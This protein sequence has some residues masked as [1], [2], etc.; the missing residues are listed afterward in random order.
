MATVNG[1]RHSAATS[2]GTN[3]TFNGKE[4][5]IETYILDFDKDIYGEKISIDFYERIRDELLFENVDELVVHMKAD[6][7]TVKKLTK[8]GELQ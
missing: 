4:K 7:L 3:P 1:T 2:I 5:T 6:V 8:S